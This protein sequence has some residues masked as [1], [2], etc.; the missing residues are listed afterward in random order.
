MTIFGKRLS[1]YVGFCKVALILIAAVG[2]LRLALS[3]GGAPNT[4][5]RWFSMTVIAWLCALYFAVRVHTSGFGSYKQLLVIYFLQNLIAQ[6]LAIT[7]ILLAIY[8]GR[9]NVFSSPEFSFGTDPWIHLAAH[10][11]IG[12]IAGALVP[13][14]IGSLVM[15]ATKKLTGSDS[16]VKS[17]A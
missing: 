13:W 11:F 1:E 12:T 14:L 9:Q 16:K 5:A 10:V 3:L 6:A 8:T 15:L 2:I 4:T 7:G 17:L